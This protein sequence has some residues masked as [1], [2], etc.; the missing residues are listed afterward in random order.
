MARSPL[1][2]DHVFLYPSGFD[3]LDGDVFPE[4]MASPFAPAMVAVGIPVHNGMPYLSE[5]I[6]SVV[7]QDHPDLEIV[8]C[9]NASDDGTQALGRYWEDRDE[10]VRYVRSE[11]NAG[12]T[13]NFNRAFE[14]TSAPFFSWAAHDDRL[15]PG[16][17][18]QCLD[19]LQRRPE[20]A[21]CVP[22]VTL[23]GEE[24]QSIGHIRG[25]AALASPDLAVRLRSFLNRSEWLMIYGLARQR[26][27]RRHHPAPDGMGSRR[28]AAVATAA[29]R[30]VLR[31]RRGATP[32]P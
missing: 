20:A 32:I 17:V 16:Y 3:A 7:G 15:C 29:C 9:D 27:A 11:V 23:I 5:A 14:L 28:G 31:R 12:A 26:G 24:G 4:D 13:A 10:R 1:T 22:S 21:M 2:D 30:P 8:V 18:S 19:S 25:D 6:E